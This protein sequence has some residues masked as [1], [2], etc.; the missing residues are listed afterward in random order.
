MSSHPDSSRVDFGSQPKNELSLLRELCDET[1][2]RERRLALI[3][4]YS[5]H[6]FVEPEH[7][8]IFESIA[9]LLPRGP[10]SAARLGVHLTNRGFPDIDVRKYI[11]SAEMR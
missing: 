5:G 6:T 10:I 7:Q 1:A 2:P 4:A 8:V 11:S 3:D 9:V